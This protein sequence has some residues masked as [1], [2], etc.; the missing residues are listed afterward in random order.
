M[1][2]ELTQEILNLK[3]GDHLCLFYEK[4]PAEQMPAL[5]PFIQD[6]LS[7]NEQFI[8]IADD[9]TVDE[10]ADRL[11]R[12][13]INIA[14]EIDRGALKLWTR[15][16]W[17]Q[18]GRLSA[19]KKSLQVLD[20]INEA[21]NTG[22]KGSRFAVEMTWALGP[23]I[24]PA[25]LEAWEATLNTIFVPGFH[26][27]ITCQYNRS[28]LSPEVMLAAFRTH[29]LAILGEHVYPNWFYEAPLILEGIASGDAKS[30]AARMEWMISVL[31]R[32]RAARQERDELIEKRAA[33]KELEAGRKK[34]ENVLSLMPAAVYTCDEHGRINFFNRR[35]V[36][37]WGREPKLNDDEQKLC[38]AFRLPNGSLLSQSETPMARALRTGEPMRNRD[39]IIEHPDGTKN[40]VCMNID[41]LYEPAGRPSGA[42]AVLQDITEWGEAEEAKRRLAAIVESSDD[43]IVSK[44]LNG[45]ITSWNRGAERLFGYSAEEAIGKSVTMLIPPR[46][47]DEE[48]KILGKI[49]RGERL[50]HY[51][52][53]RQHKDGS[54]M[55]ISLT[56]SPIRDATGVVIGASKIARDIS[57]RI[58]AEAKLREA[59]EG[60]AKAN[61]A[62]EQRVHERTA[63]LERVNAA[64]LHDMEEQRK[65]EEQLRQAQ[66][67][68]GIGTLAG[69][70]AH[71]FNNIL[72]I[73][74]GYAA[75]IGHHPAADSAI[76]ESLSVIDESIERG[77]S[78]VRQLLTL[79][80]KTESQLVSTNIN[81]VV[82]AL[83][84][85]LKQT[86]PKTIDVTYECR[87][88]PAVLADPNQI[89]QAL[90]N[91]CV[92][93]RDAMPNGGKLKLRTTVAAGGK[94]PSSITIGAQSV[95]IEVA[96][97]GTGIDAAIRS[98]IF[99]PFFTTK[100]VGEGS[101]LGLAMVYAIVKNHN[102]FIDF[103]S[104][105]KRGA[106]FRLYL[107][108]LRAEQQVAKNGANGASPDECKE[109]GRRTLL[110]AED[111]P[112]MV[113]LLKRTLAEHGYDV[114]AALDGEE[115]VDLYQRHKHEINAVLLDI[116]LP[117]LDG[118]DVL[119]KLKEENPDVH[120]LVASGYI[121]Q[122]FKAKMR[123]AGVSEFISKPYMI[124][125][126][127]AALATIPKKKSSPSVSASSACGADLQDLLG[128]HDRDRA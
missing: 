113:L 81:E 101:G 60:L 57:A 38:G 54:L 32:S 96:D 85:L 45:I 84:S 66:K 21:A 51:E 106:T 100:G 16:E 64:L 105:V 25:A 110:V 68:E 80:R 5:I 6:G 40:T 122:E 70:I 118:W 26:G 90:L 120:V 56:V 124:E 37:L 83:A 18:P 9:Q 126:I 39:V 121:D 108:V 78:V 73:V 49:Q 50:E 86:L 14:P 3:D 4:N 48:P 102:G 77:A 8:Y 71:D 31:E 82:A 99:D 33:L 93:A 87:P 41:P 104:E 27:R 125:T 74:K 58:A 62:L 2:S 10:L 17:R 35:A 63:E 94:L 97:S 115:A 103:D 20:F 92:N 7:K 44:D 12:S 29:P 19:K 79:G 117:K 69:G 43:A 36:D 28:R 55:Q 123:Q 128:A 15:K 112:A 109:N 59:S 127:L 72:N 34:I 88:L 52:T 111:E 116:G 42:I 67:M 95:C 22:F 13:G 119:L 1:Q 65:L 89:S 107:P 76:A 61:E 30:S 98:R 75:L 114:L 47:Y 53:V 24:G 23:D 46:N 91:L 11:E